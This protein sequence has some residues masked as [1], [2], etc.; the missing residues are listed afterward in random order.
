LALG[1][2]PE[3]SRAAVL[4]HIVAD[5]HAH[6][7][8]VTAGEIGYPYMVRALMENGRSD[9]LLAMMLRTDAPSYGSQLAAGATA[10]TEAWDANPKSSQDHFMLGGGEEWFYRGLAGIDFDMSRARDERITIRPAMVKGVD[11]VRA[12]YDSALGMV[13]SEWKRDGGVTTMEVVVP[14]NATAT[15]WVPMRDGEAPTEG[16]T[17]KGVTKLRAEKGAV[18]YRVGAGSHSFVVKGS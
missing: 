4:E 6:N 16:G 18:A 17:Q 7:D 13:R 15:V 9:V 11:W 1:I 10:L 5:I 3:A 12:S 14:A 8:H 2:V